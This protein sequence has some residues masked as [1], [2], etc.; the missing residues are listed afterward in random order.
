MFTAIWITMWLPVGNHF[1][2]NKPLERLL[3]RY[4]LACFM[5]A[6]IALAL[7]TTW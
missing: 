5:I 7:D 1:L 2:W 6:L 4:R 3:S